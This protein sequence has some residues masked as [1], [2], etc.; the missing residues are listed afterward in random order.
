MTQT[1]S[2]W[3]AAQHLHQAADHLRQPDPHLFDYQQ[4]YHAPVADW[5]DKAAL[6]MAWLAPFRDHE[7]GYQPWR[8]ATRIAHGILGLP[9]PDTCTTCHTR[10]T[11]YRKAATS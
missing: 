10:V 6:D 9:D 7:G 4:A 3:P 8:N 11:P 1:R 5:L 2:K